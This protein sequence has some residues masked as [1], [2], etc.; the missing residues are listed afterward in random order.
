MSWPEENEPANPVEVQACLRG[1][2]YPASKQQ[3]LTHAK[4]QGADAE[5]LIALEQVGDQ[6][7]G[8]PTEVTEA[9]GKIK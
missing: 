5:V 8:S 3:L 2:D 9:L 7:F 4:Q 6:Q 1:V